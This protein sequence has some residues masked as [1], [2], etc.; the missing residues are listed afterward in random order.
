MDLTIEVFTVAKDGCPQKTVVCQSVQRLGIAM[1]SHI[2]TVA[3]SDKGGFVILVNDL[4][5]KIR[6]EN[7][8]R[9]ITITPP[10]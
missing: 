10:S 6:V 2:I 7:K 1:G 4:D 5:M 3:A 9:F 8:G